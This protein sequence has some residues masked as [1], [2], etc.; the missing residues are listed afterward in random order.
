[1]KQKLNSVDLATWAIF[2]EMYKDNKFLD[3]LKE[4]DLQVFYFLQEYKQEKE[5]G[6]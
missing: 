1:M 2:T 3:L 5:K 6:K 4:I